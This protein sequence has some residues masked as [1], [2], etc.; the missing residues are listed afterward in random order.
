MDGVMNWRLFFGPLTHAGALDN[1][2]LLTPPHHRPNAHLIT[3][4]GQLPYFFLSP[5]QTWERQGLGMKAAKDTA[6]ASNRS[7]VSLVARLQWYIVENTCIWLPCLLA[8][9]LC[10]IPPADATFVQTWWF[11]CASGTIVIEGGFAISHWLVNSV[12]ANVPRF[13]TGGPAAPADGWRT[14]M[15]DFLQVMVPSLI[16]GAFVF[17]VLVRQIQAD[18]LKEIREHTAEHGHV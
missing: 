11:F 3:T 7:P 6:A 10:S 2:P 1:T 4:V 12:F 13:T 8:C 9:L 18:P 16:A 17:T 5:L 14:G 15:M